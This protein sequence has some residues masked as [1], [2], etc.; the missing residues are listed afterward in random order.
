[1][2]HTKNPKKVPIF[3]KKK[4]NTKIKELET[5]FS[6]NLHVEI[7]YENESKSLKIFFNGRKNPL[8]Y[9]NFDLG[10]IVDT[11]SNGDCYV[12][13]VCPGNFPAKN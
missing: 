11:D 10:K 4:L 13:F 1:V 7:R 8:L 2:I 12:G 9:K 3:S 6:E 5:V